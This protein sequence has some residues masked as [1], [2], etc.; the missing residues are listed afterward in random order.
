MAVFGFI[1]RSPSGGYQ[2]PTELA[3]TAFGL[4]GGVAGG[5]AQLIV[6]RRLSNANSDTL[7]LY[8]LGFPI[9]LSFIGTLAGAFLV[10]KEV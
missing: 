3:T 10:P 2:I 1:Q 4:L 6:G 5:M 7:P 9:G 8:A